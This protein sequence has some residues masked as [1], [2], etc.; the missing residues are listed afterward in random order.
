[1]MFSVVLLSC[2][3]LN[4]RFEGELTSGQVSSG[5]NTNTAAILSGL[6]TS[7]QGLS[8]TRLVSMRSGK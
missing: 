1:M 8:R 5:G 4:Q 7:M 2:T 3:K 6:Y